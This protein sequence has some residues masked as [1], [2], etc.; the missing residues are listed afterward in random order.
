MNILDRKETGESIMEAT[1]QRKIIIR[2]LL[3]IFVAQ[4]V[5]G[6]GIGVLYGT[7][8]SIGVDIVYLLLMTVI[9]F[10]FGFIHFYPKISLPDLLKVK[11]LKEF[12][13]DFDREKHLEEFP[14]TDIID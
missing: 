10:V 4:F 1:R 14:A 5:V 11:Y 7:E 9:V 8:D 6:L 3:G 2:L 12:G 13:T